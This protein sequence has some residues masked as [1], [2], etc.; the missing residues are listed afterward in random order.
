MAD[1]D[2]PVD[3]KAFVPLGRFK[4]DAMKTDVLANNYQ[5]T[6]PR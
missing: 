3:K 4:L 6:I 2:V 5:R 1:V